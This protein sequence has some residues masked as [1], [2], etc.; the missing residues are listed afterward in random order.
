MGSHRMQDGY[1]ERKF[2]QYLAINEIV[3]CSPEV[4]ARE[5]ATA[6]FVWADARIRDDLVERFPLSDADIEREIQELESKNA[7]LTFSEGRAR[8]YQAL[9]DSLQQ[10]MA[11]DDPTTAELNAIYEDFIQR[12]PLGEEAPSE[13]GWEIEVRIA[14]SGA[15]CEEC[16]PRTREDFEAAS[17]KGAASILRRHR[18]AEQSAEFFR[19]MTS[20]KLLQR[21]E[22]FLKEDPTIA[23]TPE[24][25][26]RKMLRERE[27]DRW[28]LMAYRDRLEIANEAV[29]RDVETTCRELDDKLDSLENYRWALST[30]W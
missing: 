30:P 1:V 15:L 10:T 18:L 2:A 12:I 23:L 11:I 6:V 25:A 28:R 19:A 13:W 21:A 14:R 7:V 27:W 29:R 5:Q 17:R 16:F 22:E 9:Y 4:K 3:E 20:E 8:Y 26:L 24:E